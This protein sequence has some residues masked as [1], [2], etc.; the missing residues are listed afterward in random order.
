MS[1]FLQPSAQQVKLLQVKT[2]ILIILFIFLALKPKKDIWLIVFILTTFKRDCGSGNGTSYKHWTSSW[3][4]G[5]FWAR[6]WHLDAPPPHPKFR[7]LFE[8]YGFRQGGF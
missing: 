7:A 1:E 2:S 6:K 4:L 8:G 5:K 3:D